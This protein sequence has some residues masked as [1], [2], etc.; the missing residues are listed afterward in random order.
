MIASLGA[1]WRARTDRERL[2]LRV[3]LVLLVCVLAPLAAMQA[4]GQYRLDARRA[5]E[6][7]N[8]VSADV[9]AIAARSA[10][11]GP[12]LPAHDG[13]LRG[14][15]LAAA[16]AYGLTVAQAEAQ[17]AN[18]VRVAFA[19]ADST[20]VYRWFDAVARRGAIV[21][22]TTIV[23]AGEGDLVTAEFELSRAR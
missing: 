15:A 2:L 19:P 18:G 12:A 9:R 22:R 11:A 16:S 1:W 4:A 3:A 17:G 20:L 6:S 8:A 21:T 14:L 13:S 10:E 7:A 23:R 5:L